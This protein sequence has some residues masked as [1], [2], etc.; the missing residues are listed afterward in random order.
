MLT[1]LSKI[2]GGFR[3]SSEML[4]NYLESWNPFSQLIGRRVYMIVV[5]GRHER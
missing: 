3:G 4:R 1:A 5:K 2:E